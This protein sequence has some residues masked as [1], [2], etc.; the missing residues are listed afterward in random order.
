MDTDRFIII[1]L[2]IGTALGL[3]GTSLLTHSFMDPAHPH[4]ASGLLLL[5]WG[6]SLAALA[7]WRPGK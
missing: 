7:C 6:A 2:A 3:A 1:A 4:L 5:G